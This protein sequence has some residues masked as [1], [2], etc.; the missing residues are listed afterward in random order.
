[1]RRK[2]LRTPVLFIIAAHDTI[3]PTSAAEKVVRRVRGPV[4]V[5]RMDVGPFDIFLGD[6]F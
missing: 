3:A 4:R 1:M 6:L 5:E 2:R